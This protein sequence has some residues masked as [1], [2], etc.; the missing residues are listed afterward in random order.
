MLLASQNIPHILWNPQVHYRIHKSHQPV[1]ILSHIKPV[2]APIQLLQYLF[3]YYAPFKSMPKPFPQFCHQN[4][5]CMSSFT[6]RTTCSAHL[7]LLDVITRILFGEEY[8]SWCSTLHNLHPVFY[9]LVFLRPNC[10][11]Q[12]QTLKNLSLYLCLI[13]R[14]QV[15]QLYKT[16]AKYKVLSI[17][18][19]IYLYILLM[20]R[21]QI[22]SK[23]ITLLTSV[24]FVE[25]ISRIIPSVIFTN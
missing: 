7:T 1:P 3:W 5:L 10:L 23:L 6:I 18:I 20:P 8:K 15:S 11:S 21:F 14:N 19:I 17:L 24:L 2:H 22:L 4:R 12:N 13:C 9:Y 16:T 25:R